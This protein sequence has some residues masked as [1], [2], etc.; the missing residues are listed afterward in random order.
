MSVEKWKKLPKEQF[1][2]KYEISDQGNIRN[3]R[4]NFLKQGITNGYYLIGLFDR[5]K[6]KQCSFAVHRLVLE[7][8]KGIDKNNPIGN[9]IDGDK[10]NNALDN[11]EW[12]TQKKNIHH[13]YENNL[14]KI[15]KKEVLKY[16]ADDNFICEYESVDKAAEDIKLTRH[17]VI[18]A[19]KG[20]NKTAGGFI[21]KY[22]NKDDNQVKIPDGCKKI[23]DFSNYMVSEKGEIYSLTTKRY[24]KPILNDNGYHYVTLCNDGKKNHYVHT[25]VANAFLKIVPGKE[26]VNHM[27]GNKTN[28]TLKNLEWVNHSE[29]R[30]HAIKLKA[31]LRSQ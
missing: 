22:K 28:N 14:V 7:A 30:I 1:G 8:F 20:K 11:L 10:L 24:L 13:A 18:R 17:A 2:D 3:D 23:K 16:N 9:H 29:N 15:N 5:L 6:N 12:S 4:D 27:D 19:L 26:F 25:I 21:W 31:S